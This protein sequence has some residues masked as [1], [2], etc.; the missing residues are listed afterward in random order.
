MLETDAADSSREVFDFLKEEGSDEAMAPSRPRT[1]EGRCSYHQVS[2]APKRH[3][4]LGTGTTDP[5]KE[6]AVPRL[7]PLLSNW[8]PSATWLAVMTADLGLILWGCVLDPRTPL[9]TVLGQQWKVQRASLGKR[10][11]RCGPSPGSQW[12]RPMREAATAR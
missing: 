2:P 12:R 6:V 7:S 8:P 10:T 3:I 9:D 11:W 5:N 4:I 1:T